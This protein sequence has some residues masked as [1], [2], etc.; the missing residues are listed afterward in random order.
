MRKGF[1]CTGLVSF[2][3]APCWRVLFLFFALTQV[4]GEV[5]GQRTD[6][7]RLRGGKYIELPFELENDFII[8]DV[9][10]DNLLPL[11]FIIDTGAENTVLLDKKMTDLLNV[12]YRRTFKVRGADVEAD[13]T[14][15][16][17]TGIDMRLANVLLARNR[18]V[19]VLEENYFNFE[20][21]IGSNIHGILG[22][23]F[24]MRFIVE[25]DYG[26]RVVILH[27]P[28]EFRRSN[29]HVE[30]P[31]VFIRNRA[32]L[33]VP[34]AVADA[35]PT[36][37]RLLVDSGAGLTLLMHTFADSTAQAEDLP[38]LTV[39]TRIANGLGGSLEG[40]VGRARSLRLAGKELSGVV[41]YF[42]PLDTVGLDFLNDREGIIGNRILKRFNVVVDYINYRVYLR[43]EGKGWKK[44]F[45][46]D[47]SGMSLLAGG[48][49]LRTY[50]VASIVPGS[51]ASRA[52]L[53]VGDRIVAVN[54]VSST[55]LSLANV[56]HKLEGKPGRKI[57]I[58]YL[59]GKDYTTVVF[60]LENLI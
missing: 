40:S 18:S 58:K 56:L 29:R 16:L 59:R 19:L 34:L 51:P 15:Y 26:R 20:Q 46:Y 57:K 13:L 28:S 52:G 35:R 10:L 25:F 17:A 32:Y 2:L 11:R 55:F 45:R 44:K 12:D 36:T 6:L 5:L 24:L 38:V 21:I 31:S 8:I 4:Q 39:P 48:T 22:A 50:N 33:E 47:R 14:A 54:G 3:L 42:Q 23:D 7:K 30:V 9:L 53:Q 43:P 60:R 1:A 41:T 49:N 27:E 37:R